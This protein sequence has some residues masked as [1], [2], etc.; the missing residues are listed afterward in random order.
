MTIVVMMTVVPFI[1]GDCPAPPGVHPNCVCGWNMQQ[2]LQGSGQRQPTS[3]DTETQVP[4]FKHSNTVYRLLF[5]GCKTTLSTV[6]AG[7]F[8]GL[9]V[10]QLI[11]TFIGITV[12]HSGPFSDLNDTLEYL[13]L[14]GNKLETLPGDVFDGFGKLKVLYQSN[15]RLKRSPPGLVSCQR[16]SSCASL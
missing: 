3:H 7:A 16:W 15:N 2:H 8:S 5:I 13:S 4:T 1:R 12:I 6:Q 11:L 10:E 14:N 9:K